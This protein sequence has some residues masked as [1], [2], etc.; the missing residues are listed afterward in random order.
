MPLSAVCVEQ[1]N[2]LCVPSGGHRSC[3][4]GPALPS[5]HLTTCTD[6]PGLYPNFTESGPLS[7]HLAPL[8]TPQSVQS[9][10][11]STKWGS[12]LNTHQERQRGTVVKGVH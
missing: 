7:S 5:V 8:W 9:L 2:I 6:I 10:A 3:Q 4:N 11:P 12:L 1:E